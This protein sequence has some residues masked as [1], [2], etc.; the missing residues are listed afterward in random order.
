MQ[1]EFKNKGEVAKYAEAMLIDDVYLEQKKDKKS[2]F[3]ILLINNR[4]K[5]QG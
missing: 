5:R 1:Q 2:K 3:N 4:Q